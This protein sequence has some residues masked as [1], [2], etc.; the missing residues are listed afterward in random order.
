HR[1][2]TGT[3][4]YLAISQQAIILQTD[5]GNILCDCI[6]Y[7]D[8]ETLATIQQRGGLKAIAIS[9]PHFYS[10]KVEWAESFD[11]HIYL[12][13]AD[14]QWVMRPSDRITFWPGETLPLVD[15]ITLVHLGRHF[16]G[17]TVL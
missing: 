2:D 5:Q 8:D 9:H 15:D 12:H 11:A 17:S 13:E 14:R 6:S 1:T 10:T 3:E 4:P 16:A 7:I